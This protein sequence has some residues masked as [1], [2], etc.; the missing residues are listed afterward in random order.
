MNRQ[1]KTL[2]TLKGAAVAASY[3]LIIGIAMY[4]VLEAGRWIA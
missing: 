4:P 3:M 2:L 1:E